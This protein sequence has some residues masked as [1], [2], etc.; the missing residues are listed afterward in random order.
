MHVA[1][2]IWRNG[3]IDPLLLDPILRLAGSQFAR[4]GPLITLRRPTWGDVQQGTVA[5][6]AFDPLDGEG[7]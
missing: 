7:R 5:T 2:D 1:A 6:L 3:R 4:L